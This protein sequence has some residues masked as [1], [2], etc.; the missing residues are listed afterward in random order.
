MPQEVYF[1][2]DF[3]QFIQQYNNL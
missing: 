2:R 3:H 1:I